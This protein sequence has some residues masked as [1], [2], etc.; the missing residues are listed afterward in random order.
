M[1][2]QMKANLFALSAILFWSTV[3]TAFK[4]S[5][6]E[7]SY[8]QLLLISS[9]TSLLFLSILFI[10]KIKARGLNSPSNR[11]ESLFS[12]FRVK[13]IIRSVALGFLNPFLYYLILFKAY[14]LLP[15]QEAISLNYT[16][17][18]IV[19][20]FSVVLLK[21]KINLSSIFFLAISFAGVVIIATAGNLADLQ[22]KN[23]EGVAYA[24]GSAVIWGLFWVLNVKDKRDEIVKLFLNFFF[25]FFFV[26]IYIIFF[27]SFKINASSSI[28]A[29]IYVGI[30]EMGIS[31]VFWL[32]AL[33]LSKTTAIISNLAYLSPF[34][35][36]FLVS[37]VLKEQIEL[38]TLIGLCLIVIGIILQNIKENIKKI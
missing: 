4:L 7:L 1:T 2:K 20:L 18:I 33:Q 34:L 15:A 5:L 27:S 29:A 32:K 19:V 13:N 12:E 24:L 16:W 14:S 37:I 17:G 36:L 23:S 11:A 3:A 28:I 22:F 6:K 9:G 31:F 30:F 25:G 35:S 8:S 10:F 21:Q 26:V 38:S